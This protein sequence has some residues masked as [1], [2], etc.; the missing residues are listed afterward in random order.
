M[1][2]LEKWMFKPLFIIMSIPLLPSNIG[3]LILLFIDMA[4]GKLRI[5]PLIVTIALILTYIIISVI[6]FKISHKK[7]RLMKPKIKWFEIYTY[8]S[9]KLEDT[10]IIEYKEI[11]YMIYYR[12]NSVKNWICSFF[13]GPIPK[14]ARIVYNNL[15]YRNNM[16]VEE[17]LGY[18][19]L[20]DI[21]KIAK[22]RRIKLII[23]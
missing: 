21:K 15:V 16:K 10:R 3:S 2:D 17:D 23:E 13:G 7:N 22:E 5:T 6:L 20:E 11:E 14:T 12:M 1:I 4:K 8:K 18:M 19:E 9:G